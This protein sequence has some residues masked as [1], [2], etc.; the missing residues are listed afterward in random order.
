MG[1]NDRA[2]LLVDWAPGVEVDSAMM[3]LASSQPAGQRT[4]A[5]EARLRSLMQV[6][7]R[8][9]PSNTLPIDLHPSIVPSQPARE[10]PY[11]IG[12]VANQQDAMSNIGRRVEC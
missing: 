8:M 1:K 3:N 2:F 11:V 6:R 12:V 10:D 4:A 7:N 9:C 5:H